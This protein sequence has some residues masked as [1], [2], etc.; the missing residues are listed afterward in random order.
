MIIG[1]R[2]VLFKAKNSSGWVAGLPTEVES[3]NI[4][5]IVKE[6]KE[7]PCDLS[8]LCEFTGLYD[9][10]KWEELTEQEKLGFLNEVNLNAGLKKYTS[11]EEVK[12]LWHGKRIWENDIINNS[13]YEE[14]CIVNMYKGNWI[15][16]YRP[17]TAFHYID[18]TVKCPYEDMDYVSLGFYVCERNSVK[19]VGNIFDNP[20]L[21]QSK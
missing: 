16:R 4:C 18:N 13:G 19:V 3:P 7:Y 11:L 17:C 2:E 21:L 9:A 14:L 8:T 1:N 15:G 6:G 10:T 20:E 12:P 5:N